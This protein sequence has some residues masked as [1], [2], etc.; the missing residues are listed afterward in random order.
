MLDKTLFLFWDVGGLAMLLSQA[1][2]GHLG[3]CHPSL[4]TSHAS[5]TIIVYHCAWLGEGMHAVGMAEDNWH[6]VL[7]QALPLSRKTLEM[8]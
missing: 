1:G 8:T 3:T 7:D 4:S 5:R 6:H 2:I